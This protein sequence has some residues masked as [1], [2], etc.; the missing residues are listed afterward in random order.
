MD[1]KK[2]H[3]RIILLL[4]LGAILIGLAFLYSYMISPTDINNNTPI[5]IEI[6]EGTST[7]Q[8]SNILKDKKLIRSKYVFLIS[9]DVVAREGRMGLRHFAQIPKYTGGCFCA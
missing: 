4:V 2:S 6:K 9:W 3:K 1:N 8:I 7:K 5:E